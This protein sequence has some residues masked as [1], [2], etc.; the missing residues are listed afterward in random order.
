M[1]VI[2]ECI[3]TVW[4]AIVFI[5]S[6]EWMFALARRSNGVDMVLV[7]SLCISSILYIAVILAKRWVD[8]RQLQEIS[9]YQLRYEIAQ[10]FPWLGAIFA[11][12]YASL[13]ARYASQWKYLADLY[14]KIKE[15]QVRDATTVKQKAMAEWKAGFLEDAQLLHLGTHRVFV[16]VLRA[17]G[18]EK[19]VER[20]F[21]KHCPRGKR[22]YDALMRDVEAAFVRQEGEVGYKD[23]LFQKRGQN[24]RRKSQRRKGL[25]RSRKLKGN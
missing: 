21:L 3:I 18:S 6:G 10:L 14:N 16:S 20:Q 24:P 1:R 9:V 25:G 17:W 12:V 4:S 11:G 7:R 15:M 13:S 2:F 5:V 22:R 8:P 23:S 19:E